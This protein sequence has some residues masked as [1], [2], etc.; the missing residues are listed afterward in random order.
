MFSKEYW[1]GFGLGFVIIVLSLFSIVTGHLL[2]SEIYFPSLGVILIIC[3][4]YI[5]SYFTTPTRENANK[6]L[7]DILVG[8]ISGTVSGLI[9]ALVSKKFGLV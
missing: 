2:L 1:G 3:I 7:T 8:T 5:F 9:V 6:I 4:F